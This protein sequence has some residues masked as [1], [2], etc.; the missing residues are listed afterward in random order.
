MPDKSTAI[1]SLSGTRTLVGPKGAE[2]VLN[3][4]MITTISPEGHLAKPRALPGAPLLAAPKDGS[5]STWSY[6]APASSAL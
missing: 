4:N 1:T 6:P 2:V 5:P 3:E